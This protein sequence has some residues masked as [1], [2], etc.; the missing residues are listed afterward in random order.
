V[1]SFV[2]NYYFS[3]TDMAFRANETSQ[4][5]YENAKNYLL[6]NIGPGNIEES[7]NMLDEI[8]DRCGPVVDAYPSWHPLVSNHD[9]M[10][11]VRTPQKECGYNGLDHTVFF[12]NGF[13]T[14]PYHDG[15][16]TIESV[17][18]LPF[19]ANSIAT[20]KAEPL[21]VS[22]YADNANP[23]LVTCEWD[24]SLPYGGMIPSS[25]AIPLILEHE[26]ACWRSSDYAE[27]WESMRPYLLG[28][29]HGQRSSLFVSQDTGQSIKKIWN[30]LI[31]S[32]AFGPIKVGSD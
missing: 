10:R 23:I 16:K 8:I 27:S 11:P 28:S 13:I 19:N 32:G 15:E 25:L 1:L 21:N 7:Q 9:A 30:L 17:E 20:I 24:K 22:L 18:K 2:I 31:S 12:V 3:G 6:R 29:P 26:L 4:S 14:C 5:G